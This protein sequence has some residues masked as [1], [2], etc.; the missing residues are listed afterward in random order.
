MLKVLGVI[1]MADD[2]S[3]M[4]VDEGSSR[5]A[6]RAGG[7]P[8]EEGQDAV[9]S[10][11]EDVSL[12]DECGEEGES[13]GQPTPAKR[14]EFEQAAKNPLEE[15]PSLQVSIM[16]IVEADHPNPSLAIIRLR[17]TS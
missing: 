4:E 16:L 12:M 2:A 10:E 3:Q 11:C 7:A 1:R 5:P 13:A 14:L 6:G 15:A 8:P 17:F 9:A